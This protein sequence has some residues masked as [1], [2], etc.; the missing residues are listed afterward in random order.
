MSQRRACY[1]I[2]MS[3]SQFNYQSQKKEEPEVVSQILK[4][5]HAHPSYGVLRITQMLHRLGLVVNH[6]RVARIVKTLQLSI[7]KKPKRHKV[8]FPAANAVATKS[9]QVWVNF[10]PFSGHPI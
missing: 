9:N 7:A 3:R 5:K 10:P 6:K 8:L 2:S 1:L 4:L